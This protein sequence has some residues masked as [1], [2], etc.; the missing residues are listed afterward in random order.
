MK[1]EPIEGL[2]IDIFS[3]GEGGWEIKG[4]TYKGYSVNAISASLEGS[5]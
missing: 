1:L 3:E 2:R 5:R 4:K